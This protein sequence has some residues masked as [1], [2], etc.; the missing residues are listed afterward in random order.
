MPISAGLALLRK[1]G[2]KI[3]SNKNEFKNLRKIRNIW[4]FKNVKLNILKLI[5]I[6][7]N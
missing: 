2:L 7:K 3:W 5:H 4:P 6:Y 1:P